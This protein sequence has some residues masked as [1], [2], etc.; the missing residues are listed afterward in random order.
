[1]DQ[2]FEALCRKL[3]LAEI[4]EPR[5]RQLLRL[6]RDQGLI[7]ALLQEDGFAEPDGEREAE[8]RLLPSPV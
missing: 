1:M 6:A 7:E 2:E 3:D 5:F 8:A 4:E